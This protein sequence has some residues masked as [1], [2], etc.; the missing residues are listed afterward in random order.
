MKKYHIKKYQ[1]EDVWVWNDFVMHAKNATFLFNRDFMDYHQDRFEDYSLV[2][3]DDEDQWVAVL[4]AN[5]VDDVVYSHQGLS[6]G[7]LLYSAKIRLESVIEVFKLLL[8]F[9]ESQQIK[10]LELKIVPSFYHIVPAEELPYILFL[11]KATLTRRDAASV[12]DLSKPLKISSSRKQGIKKGVQSQ[13]SVQEKMSFDDFWNTI[14]RPNLKDKFGL[15][16]NHTVDEITYLKSHFPLNIRQFNVYRF[17][18]LIGGATVFVTNHVVHVQYI[19]S[20]NGKSDYGNLDFLFYHLMTN[21]FPSKKYFD[22]GHSNENHGQKLN[23]GLLAWKESFGASTLVQD[24]Y[25]I[26]T[27]NHCYLNDYIL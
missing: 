23:V 3:T 6:Y 10:T 27:Q 16:P 24:F 18:E 13:L 7:G 4:P 12:I 26:P 5:R 11:S 22:F 25:T 17:D 14:L 19:S 15:E 9:L 20:K 8:Q 1:P 21:I 2:I